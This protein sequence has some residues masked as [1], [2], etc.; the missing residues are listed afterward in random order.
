MEQKINCRSQDENCDPVRYKP[1]SDLRKAR[2][3]SQSGKS[4]LFSKNIA[5]AHEVILVLKELK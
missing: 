4:L 3:G 1:V 2:F 5:K